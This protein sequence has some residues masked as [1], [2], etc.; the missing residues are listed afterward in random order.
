MAKYNRIKPVKEEQVHTN[1]LIEENVLLT[2]KN[3]NSKR[4]VRHAKVIRDFIKMYV[5][6]N[7]Q[8]YEIELDY[9]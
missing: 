3:I 7:T 2:F 1:F 6:E 8:Y 9:E 5:N 4:N